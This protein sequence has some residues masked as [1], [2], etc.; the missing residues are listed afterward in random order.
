MEFIEK[1]KLH[2]LGKYDLATELLKLAQS[3]MVETHMV[4][5]QAPVELY[6]KD[7][8]DQE[9]RF[10][11][12]WRP[13][14]IKKKQTPEYHIAY[15]LKVFLVKHSKK[16]KS[17]MKTLNVA[18]KEQKLKFDGEDF[19]YRTLTD[20]GYHYHVDEFH[21]IP[22]SVLMEIEK[23]FGED[24]DS[25]YTWNR[26]YKDYIN[27]L[28]Y[29]NKEIERLHKELAPLILESLYE[30]I[31]LIDLERT[32]EEIIGFI[33][34]S[35]KNR[36]YRKLTKQL[37]TKVHQ[38]KGEKYIVLKKD[39]KMK[40]TIIDKMLGVNEGKLTNNQI[41]FYRKLKKFIQIEIDNRNTSPFT[42]SKENEIININKR[43]FA[44]KLEMDES[45]FKHRLI[46]LQEKKDKDFFANLG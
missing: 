2:N 24:Y 34:L 10:F 5:T 38:I 19:L 29:V 35:V 44:D 12:R 40:Q 28:R 9:I 13:Q 39:S 32:D 26:L 33:T 22:K 14:Y 18:L 36:A 1:I 43:Y 45:A 15:N 27:I 4:C 17:I 41:T 23:S 8:D 6:N 31:P 46:R 42:F 25:W 16:A 30:V 37:G 3:E 11:P 20:L 7:I 21:K